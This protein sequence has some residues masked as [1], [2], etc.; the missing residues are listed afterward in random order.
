MTILEM[1]QELEEQTQEEYEYYDDIVD[2]TIDIDY[3]IQD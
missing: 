3:T 2:Y 1:Y